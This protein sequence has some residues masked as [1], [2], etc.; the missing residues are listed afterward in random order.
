MASPSIDAYR[1]N[2]QRGYVELLAARINVRGVADDTRP[3][4]RGELKMLNGEIARALAKP[5]RLLTPPLYAGQS[6]FFCAAPE[7]LTPNASIAAIAKRSLKLSAK[8]HRRSYTAPPPQSLA[9]SSRVFLLRALASPVSLLSSAP[10]ESAISIVPKESL[11][12]PSSGLLFLS[13]NPPGWVWVGFGFA[14]MGCWMQVSRR[15]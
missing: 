7:M 13:I 4:F 12:T 6:R 9:Q 14:L 8:L 3:L 10:V 5:V 1:R 2:L 15:Q 11:T